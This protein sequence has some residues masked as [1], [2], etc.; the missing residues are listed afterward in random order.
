MEPIPVTENLAPIQESGRRQTSS[1][2]PGSLIFSFSIFSLLLLAFPGGGMNIPPGPTPALPIK[3]K[4][5]LISI[6]PKRLLHDKYSFYIASAP[7]AAWVSAEFLQHSPKAKNLRW[8][9]LSPKQIQ[10]L[11][12]SHKNLK[13]RFAK[14]N[15][16]Y[17]RPKIKIND[18]SP[19][20]SYTFSN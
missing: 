15:S 10:H 11:Y 8:I 12:Y 19:T 5:R 20:F 16:K 1:R 17:R 13:N 4:T 3:A 7:R 14:G 9:L 18:D 6:Q 2:S